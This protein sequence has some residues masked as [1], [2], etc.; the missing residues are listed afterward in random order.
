M[1]PLLW[2]PTTT[3]GI[4]LRYNL[5]KVFDLREGFRSE[6][7]TLPDRIQEEALL[8]AEA[9][10]GQ[11]FSDLQG[12]VR[13][14]YQAR[15]WTEEGFPPPEKLRELGLKSAARDIEAIMGSTSPDPVT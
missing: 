8:E 3:S 7:D 15:G 10:T 11:K 1:Q 6:H 14:Y 4:P 9:A 2:G 12:M 13:E 5:E